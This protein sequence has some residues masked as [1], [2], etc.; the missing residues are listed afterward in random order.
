MIRDTSAQD[1]VVSRPGGLRRVPKAWLVGGGAVLA[2]LALAALLRAL[3]PGAWP[4]A[5]AVLGWV[6]VVAFLGD[7][8]DLPGWA[9]DLSPLEAVGRIPVE[10]ANEAVVVAM[11]AAAAAGWVA[12][13]LGFGRRD[14]RAG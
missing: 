4:A 5:W 8:L 10:A 6:V 14:L 13:A 12:S 11:A 7:T 1:Q 9:R 3:V 2:V